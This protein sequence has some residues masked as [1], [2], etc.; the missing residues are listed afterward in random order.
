MR[1]LLT[2]I[3]NECIYSKMALKNLYSVVAEAP[4]HTDV[5]EFEQQDHPGYIFREIL[6]GEYNIVYFHCNML[7]AEKVAEVAELVKKATP[8]S[9][10]VM[11]GTEVSFETRNFMEKHPEI[12]FVFRGEGETVL[13]QFI[14]TILTYEFDF[15]SIAGLAYRQDDEI[16]VNP[17]AAPVT[18]E[19]LP[20]PYENSTLSEEDVV[21]YESSR[22]CPDRCFYS[23]YYPGNVRSLSLA[24][25]CTELRYFLVKNVKRVC[26]IDKWFNYNRERA[27]RV[28][29]YLIANDNGITTFE[30]DVNGD[31]LDEETIRLLG[32]AR[33]GQL[34][35]NLD[36]ESTNPEV[37]AAAGRKSNIYQLMYN[38]TKLQE[39]ETV[40]INTVIRAGLPCENP[41][42]FARSFN[43]IYGLKADRMKLE[44]LGLR[45]GTELRR[46]AA[47][48]GYA[49]RSVAP[50]DV[51]ANDFM[52]ATELV[53]IQ[54]IGKLLDLYLNSGGFEESFQMI[55][56]D[57]H[58]KPY[59]V[60]QGLE[61]Y[62]SKNE[63]ERKLY[64][65]ENLYR[66]LYAYATQL[67]D[68]RNETLKLPVLQQVIHGDMEQNLPMERVRVFDRKGWNIN[69][70]AETGIIG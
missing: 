2:T 55:L 9:I 70:G 52:P 21:Y 19:S 69:D 66:I 30:F 27:Y 63:L 49:F 29:E 40:E 1:L 25:I 12:D 39:K 35:F 53:R 20:F 47:D 37:L 14:R 13:F 44:V 56:S 23:Q 61:E 42:L 45:K 60:L 18:L 34:S 33:S 32:T 68:K 24:R 46:K 5:M 11:G 38:V 28:W 58:M 43:K 59:G 6:R 16:Q 4:C 10:T 67:Y 64:K 50:Y 57:G 15:D 41:S 54:N 3:Q 22:G 36:V 62:I 7:N 31:L 17:M 8:T 51:I 65:E 26:F 48:Y